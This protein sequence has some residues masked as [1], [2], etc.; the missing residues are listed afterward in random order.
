[1]DNAKIFSQF[2]F[3]SRS[4]AKVSERRLQPEAYAGGGLLSVR[5]LRLSLIHVTSLCC[6]DIARKIVP[7]CGKFLRAISACRSGGTVPCPPFGP[8]I[9]C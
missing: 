9:T 2:M 8:V 7:S 3:K 4:L 5:P 6:S 1:M